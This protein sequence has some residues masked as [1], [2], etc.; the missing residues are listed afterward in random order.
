MY[1]L[2][3][4]LAD[5]YAL[6]WSHLVDSGNVCFVSCISHLSAESSESYYRAETS[7]MVTVS[8]SRSLV[9]HYS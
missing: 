3:L 7:S 8:G 5:Q 4:Y 1:N 6:N 2:S 9:G